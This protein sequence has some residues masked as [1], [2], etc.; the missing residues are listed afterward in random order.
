MGV[1][2]NRSLFLTRNIIYVSFRQKIAAICKPTLRC[3]F[4]HASLTTGRIQLEILTT[5]SFFFL[6]FL[7]FKDKTWKSKMCIW[8]RIIFSTKTNIDIPIITKHRRQNGNVGSILH[9]Y[10]SIFPEKGEYRSEQ[11]KR[12]AAFTP[13]RNIKKFGHLRFF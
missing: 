12:V 11:G 2:V 13:W 3:I 7:I 8:W 5:W 6:Q 10:H 9:G 4:S 1:V